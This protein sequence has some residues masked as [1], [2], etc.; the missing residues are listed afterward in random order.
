MLCRNPGRHKIWGLLVMLCSFLS[1]FGALDGFLF[2]F[3]AG[4]I[5]G[6]LAISWHPPKD[7]LSNEPK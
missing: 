6:G 1:L 5:G 3:F 7:G 2:G 4:L